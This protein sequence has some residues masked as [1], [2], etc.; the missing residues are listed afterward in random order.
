MTNQPRSLTILAPGEDVTAEQIQEW[1]DKHGDVF[2]LQEASDI[3][4]DEEE[5]FFVEAETKPAPT[6]TS[7]LKVYVRKPTRQIIKFAAQKSE[8]EKADAIRFTELVLRNVWL[9][10]HEEFLTNDALLMSVGNQLE[11]LIGIK[12]LELK[13]L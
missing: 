3:A 11:E 1:K 9:A 5:G 12:D 13:K 4:A 8:K 2:L 7:L 6:A 10:G